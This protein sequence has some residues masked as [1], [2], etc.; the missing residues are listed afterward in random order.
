[1]GNVHTP[2]TDYPMFFWLLISIYL[3]CLC[4]V[5]R[6]YFLGVGH[7]TLFNSCKRG[8][9][10]SLLLQA[11]I[12]LHWALLLNIVLCHAQVSKGKTQASLFSFCNKHPVSL[13][14]RIQYIFSIPEP[15]HAYW[16]NGNSKK[17]TN[18]TFILN[19]PDWGLW[20]KYPYMRIKISWLAKLTL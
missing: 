7:S 2:S 10:I 9:F 11:S 4:S 6:C 8:Y 20:Q 17:L 16:L 13:S 14:N 5:A 19:Q 15:F 18:P 3:P 12:V 1:V